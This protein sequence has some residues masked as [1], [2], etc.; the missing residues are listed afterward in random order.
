MVGALVR[1]IDTE[2]EPS[3]LQKIV[4][5][6]RTNPDPHRR[7]VLG[8]IIARTRSTTSCPAFSRCRR[9]LDLIV[10]AIT[11]LRIGRQSDPLPQPEPRR[12]GRRALLPR[13]ST[14]K[15]RFRQRSRRSSRNISTKAALLK[16]IGY[17]K[18]KAAAPEKESPPRP[19]EEALAHAVLAIAVAV[20][21]DPLRDDR[22]R[23]AAFGRR[24]L[25]RRAVRHLRQ[26]REHRPTT[27][28]PT[29][30]ISRWRSPQRAAPPSSGSCGRSN[31]RTCSPKR[32][33][34]R[35]STIIAPAYNEEV[36]IIDSVSNLLN[37]RYPDYELVVVNDGSKDRTLDVLIDHFELERRN[38]TVEPSLRHARPCPGGLRQPGDPQPRSSSTR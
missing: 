14:G 7:K 26:S 28:P 12:R 16:K 10:H 31:R 30:S 19:G 17:K 4:D 21:S 37:L 29:S 18:Q 23:R 20:S 13:S 8:R 27:S 1:L 34:C 2:S 15:R 22:V 11:E 24:R 25:H 35:R 9:I 6:V 33:C 5:L 32:A 36:S 3:H 38:M